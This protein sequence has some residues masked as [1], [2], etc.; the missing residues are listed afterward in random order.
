MFGQRLLYGRAD[1]QSYRVYAVEGAEG[2]YRVL[3]YSGAR[4]ADRQ[5]LHVDVLTLAPEAG[6]GL[7]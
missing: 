1:D 4:T 7:L 6:E 2:A 5:Y 3:L